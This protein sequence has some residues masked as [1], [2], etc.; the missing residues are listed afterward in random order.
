MIARTV[1][2]SSSMEAAILKALN[3]VIVSETFVFKFWTM[4]LPHS[5]K[6]VFHPSSH[7]TK[8]LN[9]DTAAFLQECVS[10]IF[11]R[12]PS[13]EPWHY[14]IPSRVCFIHLHKIPKFWTVTL[15]HSFKSV[16]HPS[17]QDTKVVN[18]DATSFLQECVSSIFTRYQS[19]ELWHYCIPSRVCFI[20]LHKIPK[21]WTVTLPHSFKSVFHPSSHD[22][23]VLNRDTT[24]FLQEC[25][26][27]IFP[28]Y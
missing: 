14:L 12:Y 8:V 3:T 22:T 25:V 9:R 28:R 20:H 27:S 7:D 4:T 10:S 6:S 13:C 24:A 2:W 1:P 15:L 17:S 18:R 21:F 5:F 19:F 23:K 26:S 16:F 11:T